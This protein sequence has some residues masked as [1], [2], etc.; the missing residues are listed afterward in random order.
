MGLFGSKKK[1]TVGTQAQRVVDDNALPET[2]KISVVRAIM[3]K[4][5]AASISE[6]LVNGF[7][8]SIALTAPRVVKYGQTDYSYG[9]PQGYTASRSDGEAQVQFAIE[10]EIG[11]PIDIEYLELAPINSI[12]VGWS[13]LTHIHGYDAETNVIGALTTTLGFDVFLEDLVAVYTQTSFEERDLG[14]YEQWGKAARG[15]PTP[16]R[17]ISGQLG[18]FSKRSRYVVDAGAVEDSVEVHYV[19]TNASGTVIQDM[20][21]IPVDSFAEDAEHYHVRYRYTD[22]SGPTDVERTGFW[23]Y[24]NGSGGYPD[25]DNVHDF[26]FDDFGT[27]FPFVHFRRNSEDM[28]DPSLVG[29]PDFDTSKE[30]LRIL[31]MDFET[32][33]EAIHE[34]PDID[35]VEQAMM[36]MG[37]AAKD[38]SEVSR[39]YLFDHFNA[40]WQTGQGVIEWQDEQPIVHRFVQVIKDREFE[41]TFRHAGISKRRMPGQIA[42]VGE[43]TSEEV[44]AVVGEAVEYR[45]LG[46]LIEEAQV[47]VDVTYLVYRRQVTDNLY[48]EIRVYKPE[49]LYHIYGDK[50]H[51]GGFGSDELIIPVD[52]SLLDGYN[53]P[54]RED[55]FSRSMHFI[56]NTKIVTK[57]EWYQTGI[58]KALLI[59]VAVV[60]MIYTG[61]ELY[62]ALTAAIELGSLAVAQLIITQIIIGLVVQEVA[63][64]IISTIGGELALILAA[65]ATVVAIAS[66]P[67]GIS[68]LKGA[69]WADELLMASTGLTKAIQTETADAFK[70]LQSDI[71]AFTKLIEEKESLLEEAQKLLETSSLINPLEFV[72]LA[73][74]SVLGEAPQAYYDRTIHAGN[75]GRKAI[76]AISVYVPTALTLPTIEDTLRSDFNGF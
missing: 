52:F 30:L 26:I 9:L 6:H 65:V 76:D 37:V 62:S 43:H 54:E 17:P 45:G 40:I 33:T 10:S 3:D 74:F 47:A 44:G 60:V 39:R 70:D 23:L 19:Y 29:T 28:T 72:G 68:S 15:G 61:I 36:I 22:T 63:Q 20:F 50:A 56:F 7:S 55:L 41:L 34:N 57:V 12:H 16:L 64:L 67:R 27:Y 24:E 25:I 48:D 49:L 4:N 51:V 75:A 8:K 53:L 59:V 42:G 18:H 11:F 38:E 13:V 73:P 35:D 5:E 2:I 58:F 1:V 14:A 32:V 71:E 69:P 21:T 66:G 46:G 31:N